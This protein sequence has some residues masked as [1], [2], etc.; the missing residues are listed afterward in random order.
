[1]EEEGGGVGGGAGGRGETQR[2]FKFHTLTNCTGSALGVNAVWPRV[3]ENLKGLQPSKT[4]PC[5]V[6]GASV[7]LVC[8]EVKPFVA[9][10]GVWPFQEG[11][12]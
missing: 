7:A 3:D 2:A 5:E 8:V 11:P 4:G 9:A 1:M 12:Y 10:K 6:V